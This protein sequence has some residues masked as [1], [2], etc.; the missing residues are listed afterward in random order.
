M[1]TKQIPQILQQIFTSTM[2]SSA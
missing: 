2:L 1:D